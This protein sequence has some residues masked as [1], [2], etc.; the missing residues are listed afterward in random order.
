MHRFHE[1]CRRAEEEKDVG[2]LHETGKQI[3]ELLQ[4]E[5]LELLSREREATY[6]R[7]VCQG[8]RESN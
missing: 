7:D 4:D 2:R 3:T 6:K 8:G 5:E 1:L